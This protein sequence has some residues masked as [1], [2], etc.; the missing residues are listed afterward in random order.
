MSDITASSR[1]PTV[2]TTPT[3]SPNT[4][5]FTLIEVV[6]ALTVLVGALMLTVGQ[7]ANVA[8]MQRRTQETAAVDRIIQS[9]VNRVN[10]VTWSHMATTRAPWS[11]ARY[12]TLD[13]TNSFHVMIGTN[14]SVGRD[15]MTFNVTNPANDQFDD[16]VQLGLTSS[17]DGPHDLRIYLEYWRAMDYI[18]PTGVPQDG[19]L[20]EDVDSGSDFRAVAYNDPMR[21]ELGLR[22]GFALAGWDPSDTSEG[23]SPGLRS[24]VIDPTHPLLIR[25]IAVWE[26]G[27]PDPTRFSPRQRRELFTARAP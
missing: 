24:S 8:T 22:A 19:L 7:H 1:N 10:S 14:E 2:N 13:A 23:N 27:D 20:D 9:L 18:D 11:I 12:E 5:G 17:L 6:I 15:P 16:L 21:K 4:A 26:D 25:I 3:S